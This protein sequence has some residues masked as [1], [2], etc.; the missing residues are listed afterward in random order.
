MGGCSLPVTFRAYTGPMLQCIRC[1]ETFTGFN[2]VEPNV[3]SFGLHFM[4]PSCGRRN[5]LLVVGRD[6]Y[7]ALVEQCPLP[8]GSHQESPGPAGSAA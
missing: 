3:D 5:N 4:C 8:G 7:G 6:E 1:R 2:Q